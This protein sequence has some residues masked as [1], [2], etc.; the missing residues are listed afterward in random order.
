MPKYPAEVQTD[1]ACNI[2]SGRAIAELTE[3]LGRKLRTVTLRQWS[4]VLDMMVV[5]VRSMKVEITDEKCGLGVSVDELELMCTTCK[6]LTELI[7]IV[8]G[9]SI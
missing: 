4:N 3:L 6:L 7:I 2:P 9:Q 8:R 1:T 5:D